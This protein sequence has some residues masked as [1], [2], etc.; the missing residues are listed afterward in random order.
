MRLAATRASTRA[1]TSGAGA[2]PSLAVGAQPAGLLWR[3]VRR[4]LVLAA[5][6]LAVAAAC[7]WWLAGHLAP[8]LPG[9]EGT[10]GGIFALVVLVTGLVAALSSLVPALQVLRLQPREVLNEV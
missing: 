6:G 7:S 2:T 4:N 10:G 5:I 9:T 1:E 3:T 8:L